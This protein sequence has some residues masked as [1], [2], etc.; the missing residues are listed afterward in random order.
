[1][2]CFA[3]G[4]HLATEQGEVRVEDLRIGDLLVTVGPGGP[5]LRPVTWVGRMRIDVARNAAR[6]DVAPIL[7]TAGA[8]GD[9]VPHRDLRVS[10]DHALYLDGHLVPAR[11]LVNGSTIVQEVWGPAVTYW[12]VELPAHGVLLAEGAAAESYFDDGNRHAFDNAGLDVL[13]G[14]MER[15]RLAGRYAA[16]ACAPLAVA[17]SAMLDRIRAGLPGDKRRRA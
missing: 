16:E 9:G 17:G 13:F 14:A 15:A 4:T 10:P 7:V 3:E 6:Q 1:M 5:G 2:V 12:H 8:L 11:L